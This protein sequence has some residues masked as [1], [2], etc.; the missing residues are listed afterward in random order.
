METNLGLR[1]VLLPKSTEDDHYRNR[2]ERHTLLLTSSRLVLPIA[3]GASSTC[4]HHLKSG[5]KSTGPLG[6]MIFPIVAFPLVLFG[7]AI[8]GVRYCKKVRMEADRASANIG[9]TAQFRDSS[10]QD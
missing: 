6:A 3:N 10:Q 9:G 1:P 7:T 8:L 4:H 5:L 2:A